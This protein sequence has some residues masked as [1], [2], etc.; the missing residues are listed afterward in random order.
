M[1]VLFVGMG[2]IGQRH[3]RNL[4]KIKE[5]K[6]IALRKSSHQTVIEDGKAFETESL[7]SYY[8]FIEYDSLEGALSKKPDIAFITN[9]SSLHIGTAI[10]CAKAGCHLFIEKPLATEKDR[11]IEL[12]DVLKQSNLISMVG[13][14]SRFHPCIEETHHILQNE[15]YGK[16]V[17]A[18]FNW[19]TYLPDAHPYEDYRQGYAA[20]QDLGGG[21]TFS[22]SHE[23]DLIQYFFD[24]PLSVYAIGGD[25][26]GLDID[27]DCMVAALFR[28]GKEPSTFPVQLHL[29]F[30][31]GEEQ[32][33]FTI[34]L[35]GGVLH[36]DLVQQKLQIVNHK[37]ETVL[38]KNHSG[39]QRNDL[40]ISEI[41]HFLDCLKNQK[42][43]RIPVLEGKKSL[44]I[45]L[46]IL[47]SLKTKIP[48]SIDV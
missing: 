2:S 5:S 41:N 1:K 36:C 31:Q 20:R 45:S 40:F 13:F 11:I 17:S 24:I 29:S 16:V 25:S 19:S 44:S 7:A 15:T 33:E 12:E 47:K 26:G 22:L 4:K 14:Q 9:P 8:G 3:L 46:A 48:E 30:L 39:F 32:R 6:I 35:E 38:L 23:L 28:C 34:L 37:K 27:V 10:Q 43:S 18:N 21:V 42:Q